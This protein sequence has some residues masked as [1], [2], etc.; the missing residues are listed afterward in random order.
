MR[1]K[2]ATFDL[3][4][5]L[6]FVLGTLAAGFI[7]GLIGG[8]SGYDTLR[9]PALAPPGFLFPI[10]WTLLYLLMGFSAYLIY[11][12]GDQ[13]RGKALRVYLLQ[14]LVNVLWTL[15]F[16]RLEWRGFAFFWLLG[17]IALIILTMSLFRPICPATVWLLLP[18]LLWCLFAAYLNLSYFLLN[19]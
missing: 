12:S 7:G 16:F 9:A 10:V 8:S 14:L 1:N 18:Y 2:I 5:F 4:A 3:R 15:F 6:F 13:D 19:R 17:L 11:Q